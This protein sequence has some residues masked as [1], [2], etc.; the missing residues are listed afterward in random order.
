MIARASLVT[1][2]IGILACGGLTERE[3]LPPEGQIVLAIATDA[4][5]L[6]GPDEA[7]AE[8]ERPGLFE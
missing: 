3:E 6:P 5:L 2:T 7:H 8:V 4:W 1:L